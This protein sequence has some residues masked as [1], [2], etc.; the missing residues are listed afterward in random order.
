MPRTAFPPP[1]PVPLSAEELARIAC[2]GTADRG[3]LRRLYLLPR[4]R[5]PRRG[6]W[7]HG[8]LSLLL[9]DML[10][11]ALLE[12]AGD[13]AETAATLASL[14]LIWPLL[15]ISA[16]RIHDFD[17]SAW[18]ALLHFVPGLCSYAMVA[19]PAPVLEYSGLWLVLPLVSGVGTFAMIVVLGSVPGTAGANRFGPAPPRRAAADV[20]VSTAH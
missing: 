18:W 19:L 12:I 5:L 6:F 13:D 1:P 11:T 10:G 17:W 4:G 7:L 20:P 16:K 9:L 8:V 14:P 3:A 2:G 15:A